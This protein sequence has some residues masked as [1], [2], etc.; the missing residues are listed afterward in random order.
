VL[1]KQRPVRRL[2][3]ILGWSVLALVA[4]ASA[5]ASELIDRDATGVRLAVNRSGQALLTYR[6]GGKTHRVLAWGAVN[7]IAPTTSRR[8]IAFRLDYS[9]GWGTFRR[10]VW[11]GFR[12]ACRPYDGP[13]LA[14]VV[15]ACKAADGSYWAVQSWQ[16]MLPNYGLEATPKQAVWELRLSHWT[17]PPAVLEVKLDWAYR[18]Y[19]HLYGRFSY[20]G[21]PVHGFRATP[22]GNPLDTFGRNLYLDTM[23]SAYGG[24]W[25]RE[26]SF[27]THRGS[28][29]FCYGFYAHGSRPAGDGTRYRATI[30][31]P[32]VTPDVFWQSPAPGPYDRTQDLVANDEQRELF[33]SSP[34][35]RPN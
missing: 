8:Q 10:D 4:P 35:C 31:G 6:A 3:A 1:P 9:G 19:H 15:T 24:G 33:A 7:A 30:I 32:G 27:L 2:F 12:N 5:V 23:D 17:G 26:N 28:G 29:A 21:R 13:A 25:R 18:R 14:W 34:L 22:G 16:R 20:A 11:R